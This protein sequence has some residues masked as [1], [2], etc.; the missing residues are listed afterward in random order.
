MKPSLFFSVL[1]F[2]LMPLVGSAQIATPAID[3]SEPTWLA[4]AGSWRF[5]TSVALG[6][7]SSYEKTDW[8]KVNSH[9]AGNNAL[10]VF[11]PSHVTSEIYSLSGGKNLTWEASSD[12]LYIEERKESRFSLS[13]RGDGRVSV[14]LGAINREF[15]S[16]GVLR[17]QKGFGGSFGF[18]IGDGLYGG[19][20][21]D[22][23]TEV[24]VGSKDKIWS[25]YAAGLALVY[26][27]PDS[28]MFRF[29]LGGKSSPQV[30]GAGSSFESVHRKQTKQY[31]DLELLWGRWFLSGRS[32]Q[33]KRFAAL[34]DEINQ[35]SSEQ[36]AGIGYRSLGFSVIF[37]GGQVE[38][39][40][41]SS[42]YKERNFRANL[43]IGF[44]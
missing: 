17:T 31:G 18:R 3:P 13:V 38:A 22:R 43:A 1:F 44:L 19:M 8:Q 28:S 11:Q 4:S 10:I 24:T 29:E 21:M 16:R 32:T 35:Q 14:G 26:G 23:L 5:G 33:T 12:S 40:E 34:P 37:Y 7:Q 27:D 15:N 30:L 41:K 6:S 39:K 9:G 42:W 36:R 20:G 25:D 2:C